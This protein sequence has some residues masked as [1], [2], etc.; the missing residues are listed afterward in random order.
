M[1][2]RTNEVIG[3]LQLHA[4]QDLDNLRAEF[5][6]L[7]NLLEVGVEMGEPVQQLDKQLDARGELAP[8]ARKVLM[9]AKLTE[10]ALGE[11]LIKA[12]Q[13]TVKLRRRI[14][15]AQNVQFV[16]QIVVAIGGATLLS[17]IGKE[18]DW[19]K[20]AAG[21]AALVGSILT[22]VVQR[23]QVGT[24]SGGNNL[25]SVYDD[26]IELK[27]EAQQLQTQLKVSLEFVEETEQWKELEKILNA[28]N[29]ITSD[30]QTL[31]DKT[32]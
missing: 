15:R 3:F 30:I 14:K 24:F 27:V 20:Y 7:R 12:D 1:N 32:R 22:L 5:P 16:S 9:Y 29:D 4:Q 2:P 11:M 10:K 31:W 28:T 17:D 8:E 18:E 26:L 25:T 13:M 6:E 21:A 23:L 19:V